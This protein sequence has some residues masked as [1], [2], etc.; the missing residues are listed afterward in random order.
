M[1]INTFDVQDAETK[2]C[3]EALL[4]DNALMVVEWN[5]LLKDGTPYITMKSGGQDVIIKWLA[6]T[7]Y[8]YFGK[9][10]QEQKS[11]LLIKR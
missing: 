5:R 1:W 10:L 9:Q 8:N 3:G 4:F 2:K 6:K 7:S 11:P